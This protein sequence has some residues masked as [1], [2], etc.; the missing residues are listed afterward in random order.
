MRFFLFLPF[1]F[2]TACQ[3]STAKLKPS[4]MT[5]EQ[6]AVKTTLTEFLA[7]GDDQDAD[8]LAVVLDPTYRIMINQFMGGD[9]VTVIDRASYLG[10][11][12][13][14]KLG[15][16]PRSVEWKSIEVVGNLAHVRALLA[17]TE[18]S[19]DSQFILAKDK[20][21]S[22]RLVSDAPFVTMK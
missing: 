17:S 13:Q 21:G 11:I 6:T 16:T 18:M 15:G 9:G 14:K 3:P 8:R 2:F 12:E 7:A 1:L 5:A 10:M 20:A 19:F 4:A 22:W